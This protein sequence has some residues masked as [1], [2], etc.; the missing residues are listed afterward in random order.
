MKFHSATSRRR[1]G[2]CAN[3]AGHIK[4][5]ICSVACHVV[6]SALHRT[7]SE[8]NQKEVID[9]DAEITTLANLAPRTRRKNANPT[10]QESAG[11]MPS[12][13]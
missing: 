8:I 1:N 2:I 11:A 3:Q 5:E 13:C 4:K 9:R 7:E 12:D 10:R 6:E